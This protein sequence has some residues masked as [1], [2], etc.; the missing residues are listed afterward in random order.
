[1]YEKDVRIRKNKTRKQRKQYLWKPRKTRISDF[2]SQRAFPWKC[3][4]TFEESIKTVKKFYSISALFIGVRG[5]VSRNASIRLLWFF[6][7]T[8][9]HSDVPRVTFLPEFESFHGIGSSESTHFPEGLVLGNWAKTLHPRNVG[10]AESHES[11]A[12]WK[13]QFRE[14][15][16]FMKK[17]WWVSSVFQTIK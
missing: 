16:T 14:R 7:V 4:Q 12:G 1:M 8:R 10:F 13:V 17:S 2:S 9:V 15:E 6:R 3:L 11:P 5:V